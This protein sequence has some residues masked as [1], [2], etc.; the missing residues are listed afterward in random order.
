MH[1]VVYIW[2]SLES[3]NSSNNLNPPSFSSYDRCQNLPHYS[4]LQENLLQCTCLLFWG[5]ETLTNHSSCALARVKQRRITLSLLVKIFLMQHRCCWPAFHQGHIPGLCSICFPPGAPQPVLQTALQPNTTQPIGV[6]AQ[7]FFLSKGRTWHFPLLSFRRSL[8]NLQQLDIPLNGSA[9][10]LVH[11][12]VL[13]L[14]YHLQIWRGYA[15]SHPLSWSLIKILSS[16]G[17]G[18]NPCI[19]F[20]NI[21]CILKFYTFPLVR[22]FS[23]KNKTKIKLFKIKQS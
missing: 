10:H 23:I 22:I 20:L 11:Q 16:T 21:T 9:N 14:L 3:S 15:L 8:S 1:I 4:D 17:L 13:L 6:D 19:I 7:D 5:A 18:I 12:P 2:R